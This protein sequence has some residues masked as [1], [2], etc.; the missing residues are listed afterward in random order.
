MSLTVTLLAYREAENLRWLLPELRRV[1]EPLG[2]DDVEYLIV[3]S[4]EPTDDT[5]EVCK[6]FGARYVNQT[7]PG[8]GGAYRA[9]IANARK[10]LFLILDADGS[11]DYTQ[12]PAMYAELLNGADVVIG[13]RYVPGGSTDDAKTSQLMSRVLNFFFRIG[14]GVDVRDF[15]GSLRLCRTRD[16]RQLHLTSRNFDISE[17]LILKLKLLKGN[18]INIREVPI[19]FK[20]RMMGESKRSLLKFIVSFGRML[21]DC[22]ALRF[23]ARNGYRG[24]EHDEQARRWTELFLYLAVGFLTTV[25][26]VW[27]FWLLDGPVNYLA[28]DLAAWIV[29]V[30]FA[31]VTNKTVVFNDWDWSKTAVRRELC[32]FTASRAA[33]GVLDMLMLWFMV[34]PLGMN[35]KLS[36]LID[37]VVVIV[38]NYILSKSFVFNKKAGKN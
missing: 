28:A 7:E 3:D 15:S 23:A 13:S 16:L 18:D 6:A 22:F 32:G 19:S 38:L 10:D 26:N 11:Q 24:E 17:E 9:A 34:G 1:V 2:I 12:I 5:E 25:V 14:I 4:A 27:T 20:K 8:Y 37:S 30:V 29:A 21:V 35:S 36:K 33:T 31:F